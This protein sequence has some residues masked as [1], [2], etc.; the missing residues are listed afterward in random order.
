MIFGIEAI[1]FMKKEH[2]GYVIGNK[3]QQKKLDYI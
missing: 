1:I 3:D 2:I